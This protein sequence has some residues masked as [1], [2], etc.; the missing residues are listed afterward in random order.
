[1]SHTAN[2]RNDRKIIYSYILQRKL[3]RE[4]KAQLKGTL[5]EAQAGISTCSLFR[6]RLAV[7]TKTHWP[8]SKS[9]GIPHFICS[10][11]S[12][13]GLLLGSRIGKSSSSAVYI[14]IASLELDISMSFPES[15]QL[16]LRPWLTDFLPS[17]S[18]HPP[19]NLLYLAQ[20]S[21]ACKSRPSPHPH[22]DP[23]LA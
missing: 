12:H 22:P 15:S 9:R 14:Q 18:P 5:F 16:S 3:Q 8:L 20:E 17:F 1:M 23:T 13:H 10:R 6:C 2:R 11:I 7:L 21:H 4:S 19:S